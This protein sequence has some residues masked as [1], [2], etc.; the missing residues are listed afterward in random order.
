MSIQPELSQTRLERDLPF[1]E[2]EIQWMVQRWNAISTVQGMPS[3]HIAPPAY[4]I[5]SLGET[6]AEMDL[7]DAERLIVALVLAPELQPGLLLDLLTESQNRD[8]L[9]M[10]PDQATKKLF[11]T[12]RTVFYLLGY[13]HSDTFREGRKLFHKDKPLVGRHIVELKRLHPDQSFLDLELRLS[14]EYK[15]KLIFDSKLPLE[16]T[17]E[18]P[19][20]RISTALSWKELVLADDTK[21]QLEEVLRWLKHHKNVEEKMGMGRFV[22]PGYRVLFY[23][24]PGTGKTL[25]ASILG[26]ATEKAVYRIDLSQVVSKYIGETEKNLAKV[27]DYAESKDWILFFDEADSLF[28][29]RGKV[30]DARD[31]YA[32]QEI[33]FLLQRLEDFSNLCIMATNLKGNM[34]SAFLRRFQ[35]VI[36][37]SMPSETER[38]QLWRQTLPSQLDLAPELT[39]EKMA[40]LFKLTGAEIVNVVQRLCLKA[41]DENSDLITPQDLLN[42]VRR[43]FAKDARVPS[44]T[45]NDLV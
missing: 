41:Q 26:K 22:K 44:F 6:Y 3:H 27:F 23:G 30:S 13:H 5:G 16:A 14:P 34:D 19:A 17:S 2:R 29:K 32:N 36:E 9:G 40:R 12:V 25:A 18:F 21:V 10:T 42:A 24:M 7:N 45:L 15:E 38:L 37:F 31:R 20:H 1:L 8:A 35:E 39:L 11:P 28:G 33:S 4:P 43:E